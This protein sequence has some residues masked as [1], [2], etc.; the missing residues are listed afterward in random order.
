M[1]TEQ[2]PDETLRHRWKALAIFL[3]AAFMTLLDVS[4]VNVALPSIRSG[5]HASPDGLQWILSGYALTF[6]LTLVPAG[7]LGDARSRR[8]VFMAGLMVFT[9]AS[10]AAGVAQNIVWLVV[11]RLVQGMAG[12]LL[13]PQIAGLIQVMFR[14]PE[15]GRAFGSLGATIGIATAAGPVIGGALIALAGAQQGWRWVF[16]VNVPV[17]LIALPLAWRLLPAPSRTHRPQGLDPVGVVLLGVG[18]LALLLPFVQEQQWHGHTKW[19][20]VLAAAVLLTIFLGWERRHREPM[21]DLSLFRR[22]SYALGSA[23]AL[24]YFAGFTAIFFI[25]T[26]Y[27]QNGL[28]YSALLAGLSI[29]PFAVG[30]GVAA[31]VGGRIVSRFGRPLVATG[32]LIVAAGL[33]AVLLAVHA[34]PGRHVALATAAPFLLAGLGSGLV[35]APNQT[36]TLSEVPPEGGGSA[37]G[38]LQTGQRIGT[39]AGIAAVGAVFFAAVT[40]TRGDWADAFQRGLLVVLAFVLAA[41][42][43]AVADLVMGRLETHPRHARQAPD[44]HP[45]TGG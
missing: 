45:V 17:G 38:V 32:L 10:V 1:P 7:R 37:A 20:L 34:D 41:L 25:F 24:L 42:G 6:G 12:G 9:L 4:I 21:I 3:V 26:L 31:A 33:A 2:I 18:V 44:R 5:L 14:G 39:S 11:A 30:S 15:R 8:A 19:L 35:I 27:L 13:N 16:Y 29:T 28:H 43:A 40:G 22:R 23:I 36:I